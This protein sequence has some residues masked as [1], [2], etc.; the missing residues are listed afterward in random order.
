MNVIVKVRVHDPG[1]EFRI[2]AGY[3]VSVGKASGTD[4]SDEPVVVAR[5]KH[6]FLEVRP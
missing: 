3:P 5:P 6:G 2:F 4:L 1:A